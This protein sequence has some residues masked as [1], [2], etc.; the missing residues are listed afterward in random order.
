MEKKKVIQIISD[1]VKSLLLERDMQAI[2][3]ARKCKM[4][5]AT[6]SKIMNGNMGI[7]VPMAITLAEGLGVEIED[8]LRGIVRKR[9]K[10]DSIKKLSANKNEFSI[11]VLSINNK[12][13]TCV[14]DSSRK[15]VGTSELEGG[16]DLTGTSNS[17]IGLIQEAIY[18][19]LPN[20]NN[21]S[22]KLKDTK[23]NLVT[24]SYEFEETR[25]KFIYFAKKY[26]KDVVLIS[27]WQITYLA[28]FQEKQGISLIIDKGVSL[29]Y[30]NNSHLKK[31]GGWKFPV[32]D[33]GGENWLGLETIRHTIQAAE[34]YVSMSKLA[35]TVLARFNGKIEKITEACFIGDRDPDIYSSFTSLLLRS[36]F[37]KESIAKEILGRGFKLIYM[38]IEKVDSIS[39]NPLKIA[40][41]GSLAD[42][43]KS[44][45]KKERLIK[46]PSET[47]KVKLLADITKDYLTEHGLKQTNL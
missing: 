36:Y 22:I 31:L 7:S 24:Q 17:L 41:S 33:L 23:L 39:E 8:I 4:S 27:D 29:C 15:V 43:Y 28:A 46:F 26:F 32:Y 45:F 9:T 12:R 1:N 25:N 42:I 44:F 34:G 2:D 18:A 3:L 47:I 21:P 6:I 30:K 16:L 20:E 38:A 19:A 40:L 37:S 10:E 13:I 35:R 14:K 5:S 11:G